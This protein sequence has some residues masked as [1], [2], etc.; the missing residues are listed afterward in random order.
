MA[1]RNSSAINACNDD[2]RAKSPA[3]LDDA[4]ASFNVALGNGE[5]GGVAHR[6]PLSRE[7]PNPKRDLSEMSLV[8][9]ASNSRASVSAI[10]I[11]RE[12]PARLKP[13]AWNRIAQTRRH[14]FAS[15]RTTA[16]GPHRWWLFCRRG[17]GGDWLGGDSRP[18]G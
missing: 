2:V 7:K 4:V 16:N 8:I 13:G 9:Q 5:T 3:T 10:L 15:W 11:A 12:A 14:P 1:T 18:G 6:E 17:Q